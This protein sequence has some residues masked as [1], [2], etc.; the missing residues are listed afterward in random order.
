MNAQ[1]NIDHIKDEYQA[2]CHGDF[3]AMGRLLADEVVW[4]VG[5][6]AVASGDKQGRDEVI[7]FLRSVAAGTEQN[8]RIQVHDVLA[9]SE[10]V[11]VL[12]HVTSTRH[13]L[14]Y[15]ADEVHLFHVDDEGLIH[16]AWGFTAEPGGQG[17]FWF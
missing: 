8:F 10:H 7:D 6:H 11:V 2:F 12:C 16:E 14:T 4:H 15:R 9:N 1:L 17:A 3:D 13:E 5:G